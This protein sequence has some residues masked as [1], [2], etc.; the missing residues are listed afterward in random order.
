[1]TTLKIYEYLLDGYDNGK[2]YTSELYESDDENIC[3]KIVVSE[4]KSESNIRSCDLLKGKLVRNPT[5][6]KTNLT[7]T[8]MIDNISSNALIEF[9]SK[10]PAKEN[11]RYKLSGLDLY[12]N[13]DIIINNIIDI[14]KKDWQ[15]D[16][17]NKSLI[18]Y[19]D[20]TNQKFII[21]GDLH[22]SFATFVRILLRL[23]IMNIID[24]NSKLKE[25]Y[26]IIFLGD[27][28]DRGIYGY[29]IVILIFKLKLINPNNIHINRGNHEEEHTNSKYGLEEQMLVQF[30]N[31]DLH[32]KL[33]ESFNYFHSALLIKNP[34]NNKYIY[35]AHGGLPLNSNGTLYNN[36]IKP[37]N[38]IIND[39]DISRG[40][41]PNS[42]R[43]SDFNNT[44]DDSEINYS[45][46]GNS[47]YIGQ[48]I[49]NQVKPQIEL[50]IRGHE[51][52]VTN[53]KILS[54]NNEN[55]KKYSSYRSFKNINTNNEKLDCKGFTHNLTIQDD[56][57]FIDDI[58]YDELLPVVVLTTNT[59]YGR[60]LFHDSFAILSFQDSEQK[61][62]CTKI[63]INY[64]N[65]P[66][67]LQR[68]YVK[69]N[70]F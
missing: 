55:T 70:Y 36:W 39:S 16:N 69:Y 43:W 47:Y 44:A 15:G 33:N 24:E 50:I 40:R 12:N 3:E 26:N 41:G 27:F 9:I 53:T 23:K 21:M 64:N 11:E 59:D 54:K 46:G 45:R 49:L 2:Y 35:L 8:F 31:T 5:Q 37:E 28:V 1:M 42:I 48:N 68:F 67:N 18:K 66:S 7:K 13:I 60:D 57:I 32:N 65:Q 6:V 17:N 38:T 51:D 25:N 29:E 4:N 62:N 34:H 14:L 58:N 19:I 52:R 10:N 22:G 63:K 56:R 30:G 20:G 61:R